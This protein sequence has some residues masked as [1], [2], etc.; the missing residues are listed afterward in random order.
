MFYCLSWTFLFKL[1]SENRVKRNLEEFSINTVSRAKGTMVWTKDCSKNCLNDEI[2]KTICETICFTMRQRECNSRRRGETL[3]HCKH[4][5]LYHAILNCETWYI[6]S[7]MILE[8]IRT[9]CWFPNY[10]SHP[11]SFLLLI[12]FSF[13]S[14][15]LPFFIRSAEEI[16]ASG[17]NKTEEKGSKQTV[18]E[19]IDRGNNE[20]DRDELDGDEGRSKGEGRGGEGDGRFK[21]FFLF[22][23]GTYVEV[24][25]NTSLVVCWEYRPLHD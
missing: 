25:S 10:S 14:L 23:P 3:R 9:V 24:Q 1:N 21:R 8:T 5:L 15:S 7:S 2:I 18:V 17:K 22:F 6:W 19:K 4:W 12:V 13:L 11:F 16:S 20:R